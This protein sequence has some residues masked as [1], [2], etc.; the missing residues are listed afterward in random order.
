MPDL[1][2]IDFLRIL[3][4]L[5]LILSKKKQRN[6]FIKRSMG[7]SHTPLYNSTSERNESAGLL[8]NIS[9]AVSPPKPD[10]IA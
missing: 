6:I 2:K 3:S 9:P 7:L 4:F 8:R 5:I 10:P 1:Y